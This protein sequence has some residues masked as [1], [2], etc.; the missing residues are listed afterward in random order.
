MAKNPKQKQTTLSKKHLDRMHR[1]QRQTRWII[2]ASVAVVILVVLVIGYGVLQDRVLR[3]RRPVAE[4][5]GERISAQEFRN[6]TKY[7]RYGIIRNAESNYQLASMFGGDPATLQSFLS[8]LQ[9][10]V[11][12]LDTFTAGETAINQMVDN[13]LVVQEAK[14]RGITVSDEE[15]DVR[16]QEALGYYANGTPTPTNTSTPAATSTLSA[17]QISMMK[18]TATT[19]L[20]PTPSITETQATATPTLEPSPTPSASATPQ[21]SPTP[22]PTSTPY[23]FEG[24]QNTYATVVADFDVNFQ[25]P[26]ETLRYVIE[27]SL[28]REKLQKEIVGVVSCEEEQVWAQHIL[29]ADEALAIEIK[30]KLDAGEDWLSLVETYSTDE[31]SKSQGGDLGWFSQGKMVKEFEE[32][33][34]ALKV[35]EVSDPVNSQFGWHIIRVLGHENRPLTTVECQNQEQTKFENWLTEYRNAAQVQILDYWQEIVPLQPTLS[36]EIQQAI[37]QASGAT[38]DIPPTP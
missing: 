38:G 4:I 34:F 31:G 22:E 32:A 12:Q 30:G 35:G 5:N 29:V 18:P 37:E 10:S 14:K 21:T 16:L 23:T 36:P 13:A 3:Y 20:T 1:E 33:A 7:Y 24:Y 26:P 27:T 8:Q 2:I 25:V 17:L 28:F 6:Y 11:Q 15:I 9:N 19:T